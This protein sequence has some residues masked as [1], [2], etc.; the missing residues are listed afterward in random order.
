MSN[1]ERSEI[2]FKI[3]QIL[4]ALSGEP[5]QTTEWA[6]RQRDYRLRLAHLESL[7]Q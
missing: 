7:L 1:I 6:K 3:N 4:W 5:S 2:Q